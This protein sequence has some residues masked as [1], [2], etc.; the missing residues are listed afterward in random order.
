MGRSVD[1][2]PLLV[3]FDPVANRLGALS[4]DEGICL[5]HVLLSLFHSFTILL[6]IHF[7]YLELHHGCRGCRRC[8]CGER[9]KCQ[10]WETV[11]ELSCRRVFPGH[12]LCYGLRG[13]TEYL[14]IVPADTCVV[15]IIFQILT[16]A[17]EPC[18]LN[19]SSPSLVAPVPPQIIAT[20]WAV[21]HCLTMW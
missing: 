2:F 9:R 17:S 3:C 20:W 4:Q 10:V 21:G 5:L 6:E 12:I 7:Q 8:R 1:R 11:A 14:G 13:F 19:S 15:D 16:N 18:L